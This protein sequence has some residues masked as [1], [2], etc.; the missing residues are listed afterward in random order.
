MYLYLTD[1]EKV[2][3]NE[4]YRAGELDEAYAC[5]SRSLAY[6]DTNAL[7][8]ANRALVSLRLEKFES[9]EDDCSRALAL[10]AEYNKARIRRGSARLR[11]GKYAQV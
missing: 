1:R 10:D 11:L 7:V 2:K 9:A 5:Y 3:G 6:N 8:F 4:S